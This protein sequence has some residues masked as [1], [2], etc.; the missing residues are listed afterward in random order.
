M[1][2]LDASVQLRIE[3]Q[4]LATLAKYYHEKGN[5]TALKGASALVRQ[6][7]YDAMEVALGEG[8]ELVSPHGAVSVLAHLGVLPAMSPTAHGYNLAEESMGAEPQRRA[9][10]PRNKPQKIHSI[11]GRPYTEEQLER[12][13]RAA[14]LTMSAATIPTK[15]DEDSDSGEVVENEPDEGEFSA[16]ALRHASRES[17]P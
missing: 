2:R 9:T 15:K 7:V 3:S 6:A 10:T 11:E 12:A 4:V 5:F 16:E 17:Q 8:A 14:A 13:V 1:A